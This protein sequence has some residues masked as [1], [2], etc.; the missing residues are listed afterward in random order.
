M[1]IAALVL[2]ILAVLFFFVFFPIGFILAILAIVFGFIARA[3][4][5]RDPALG[6]KGMALAGIILGII[7]VVLVVIVGIIIGVLISET[8][9]GVDSIDTQEIQEQI[10]DLENP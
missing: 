3:R 6:R 2:G 10:E 9:D 8:D 5:N 1:A 7:T 4:A